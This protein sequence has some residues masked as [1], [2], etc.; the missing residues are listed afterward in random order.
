M[1]EGSHPTD[2]DYKATR[3]DWPHSVL[4]DEVR[5]AQKMAA[6]KARIK[7]E[8]SI[9][10]LCSLNHP[11]PKGSETVFWR[12]KTPPRFPSDVRKYRSG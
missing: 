6:H 12:R 4:I 9:Y 10:A 2:V 3:R 7:L 5:I 8:N 11:E 1:E